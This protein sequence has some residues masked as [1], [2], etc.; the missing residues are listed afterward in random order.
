MF[1]SQKVI[2]SHYGPVGRRHFLQKRFFCYYKFVQTT[3]I[4]TD[5]GKKDNANG[6]CSLLSPEGQHRVAKVLKQLSDELGDDIW[7]MPPAS[8]HITL[9]EIT[10]AK[11]YPED[12]EVLF[13][14]N[15]SQ[16]KR[17]LDAALSGVKPIDVVFD[18]L[19]VSPDAIIIRSNDDNALHAIRSQLVDLL[20]LPAETKQPPAIVHSSI[21]RFTKELGLDMIEPIVAKL[22]ISFTETIAEFQLIHNGSPHMLNYQ[23][24]SRHPLVEK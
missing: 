1:A 19:E 22:H 9:C 4:A 17:A 6:I 18:R 14:H 16:Y 8:L 10:Q 15:Q 2:P 21:A 7:C 20:P 11:P 23:I 3:K 12:K 13:Q 5:I 24:A